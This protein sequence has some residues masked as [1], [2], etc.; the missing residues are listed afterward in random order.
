MAATEGREAHGPTSRRLPRASSGFHPCSFSRV[1]YLTFLHCPERGPHSLVLSPSE[2]EGRLARCRPLMKLEAVLRFL[3]ARTQLGGTHP[4]FQAE[5]SSA[6]GGATAL[7]P[8]SKRTEK[9]LC[10]QLEPQ[11]PLRARVSV[12]ASRSPGW[13]AVLR[14]ATATRAAS[15]A[16]RSTPGTFTRQIQA[17]FREPR[18]RW[19]LAPE[20]TPAPR[21]GILC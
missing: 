21:G 18:L 9:S 4:D 16:G 17:A 1:D 12:V 10:G 15:V 19:S 6:R 11:L 3:A 8:A 5:Q 7:H 13:P 14:F 2:C 20:P